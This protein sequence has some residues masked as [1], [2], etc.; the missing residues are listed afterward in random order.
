MF[1]QI[2]NRPENRAIWWRVSPVPKLNNELKTT[3]FVSRL[4]HKRWKFAWAVLGSI[5]TTNRDAT[6]PCCDHVHWRF[7]YQV[8]GALSKADTSLKWTVA[9]V[10]RV[11]ALERADCTQTNVTWETDRAWLLHY[12][13]IK[14]VT[15]KTLIF[16]DFYLWSL[17]PIR[18][19]LW[20]LIWIFRFKPG[21]PY[22]IS[23]QICSICA[24]SNNS[25]LTF[26]RG[27]WC[28]I[29]RLNSCTK[30][31]INGQQKLQSDKSYLDYATHQVKKSKMHKIK[32]PWL[33][34]PATES[35]RQLING[36]IEFIWYIGPVPIV[37][38]LHLAYKCTR[39]R[40]YFCRVQ[41]LI[42]I[43]HSF[44]YRQNLSQA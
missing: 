38:T 43:Q 23:V 14:H 5:R 30:W 18:A 15:C 29:M 40:Q 28:T 6:G 8:T 1:T 41:W 22:L 17:L 11:S 36:L 25:L 9:L 16:S 19:N 37:V 42:L 33:C 21:G 27:K 12:K 4:I 44:Q 2:Y 13:S 26:Y 39:W 20:E 7:G 34:S 24:F 31:L 3:S 35:Q 10:P 32:R